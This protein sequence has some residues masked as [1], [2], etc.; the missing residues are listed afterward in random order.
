MC[1]LGL[2]L[3][4]I[5]IAWATFCEPAWMKPSG[6]PDFQK[7]FQPRSD[8]LQ[9]FVLPVGQGSCELY[10]CP[11]PESRGARLIVTDCG[12]STTPA[13]SIKA[14]ALAFKQV[15]AVLA[16]V[17][18]VDADHVNLLEEFVLALPGEPKRLAVVA[19]RANALSDSLRRVFQTPEQLR[20][21]TEPCT[22]HATCLGNLAGTVSKWCQVDGV[23]V[24]LLWANNAA[25]VTQVKTAAS[26]GGTVPKASG[27]CKDTNRNS[28]VTRVSVEA[29]VKEE[30]EGSATKKPATMKS[31]A[32]G[33]TMV[34]RAQARDAAAAMPPAQ[35]S[36]GGAD[37][38][39]LRL[40]H[41][42]PHGHSHVHFGDFALGCDPVVE[43]EGLLSAW[44]NT[45]GDTKCWNTC[46]TDPSV[47]GVGAGA[48][49]G[50]AGAGAA[51]SIG[52]GAATSIGAGAE[53]AASTEAKPVSQ[54]VPLISV[55]APHHGASTGMSPLLWRPFAGELHSALAHS[56]NHQVALFISSAYP[57][58]NV[59]WHPR[60]AAVA[61]FID[62]VRCVGS[63]CGGSPGSGSSTA[64]SSSPDDSRGAGDGSRHGFGRPGAVSS[65]ADDG[66]PAVA[67]SAQG[68]SGTGSVG[69]AAAGA[70]SGRSKRFAQSRK[71]SGAA[72]L[73]AAAGEEDSRMRALR[74]PEG[75]SDG[76]DQPSHE[77]FAAAGG[78][79][80][81]F[82][83]TDLRLPGRVMFS[84]TGTVKI[85]VPEATGGVTS[86]GAG[87]H[88]TL[89]AVTQLALGTSHSAAMETVGRPV[90]SGATGMEIDGSARSVV[91]AVRPRSADTGNGDP[92]DGAAAAAVP[93][94]RRRFV[95]GGERQ[96]EA[97]GV[98]LRT[99]LDSLGHSD[100]AVVVEA[101][102]SAV[103]QWSTS[104]LDIPSATGSVKAAV[105]VVSTSP[106]KK[107]AQM[108]Y[109]QVGPCSDEPARGVC[110]CTRHIRLTLPV[111]V[112]SGAPAQASGAASRLGA[113]ASAP[114]RGSGPRA[115]P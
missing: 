14:V 31:T 67:S 50:V 20:Q 80:V 54:I 49:A 29:P 10:V 83:A 2:Q 11:A 12:S 41:S 58:D 6:L 3:A 19:D 70:S 46:E 84:C 57:M 103:E 33:T 55:T 34:T 30:A 47:R 18:H 61:M 101:K 76:V 51:T 74:G 64:G 75:S 82:A 5:A 78:H 53:S 88:V 79:P 115:S 81:A 105:E 97:A 104:R 85:K 112:A 87:A 52:A 73:D 38:D 23:S 39:I 99:Y 27:R 86:S 7:M 102:V 91:G 40:V 59:Y 22:S 96:L 92:A 56:S 1:V 114:D 35:A 65:P 36:A 89:G 45:A 109:V 4:T 94:K 110:W 108:I 63:T 15:D 93:S 98:A 60:C 28:I 77:G 107:E 37:S 68:G 42:H 16:I 44:L 113:A 24:E 17:S 100:D 72:G 111:E 25:T 8:V 71:S 13:I 26:A 62:A 106:T 69:G 90:A 9:H 32:A 95:E 43:Y 48:G 66:S 21:L